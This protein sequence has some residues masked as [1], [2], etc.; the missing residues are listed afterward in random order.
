[1]AQE[2]KPGL[3]VHACDPSAQ[4]AKGG[5]YLWVQAQSDLFS[6]FQTN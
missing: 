5:G 2:V 1:M 6:K 3:M 4:K